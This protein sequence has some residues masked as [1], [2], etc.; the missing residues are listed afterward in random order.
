MAHLLVSSFP[1]SSQ[2]VRWEYYARYL[3]LGASTLLCSLPCHGRVT[4]KSQVN[5]LYFLWLLLCLGQWRALK[6]DWV[7]GQPWNQGIHRLH[8]FPPKLSLVAWY[9]YMWKSF[10]HVQLFVTPWTIAY[11]APLSMEFRQAYWEWVA[12]PFS[13]GSSQPRD[14]TQVSCIAGE[15]FTIWATR[16]AA[17]CSELSVTTS[18]KAVRLTWLLLGSE[19]FLIPSDLECV[20]VNLTL[21]S[22]VTVPNTWFPEA[23]TSMRSPFVIKPP[24]SILSVAS[25]SF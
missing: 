12:V 9:V 16:G 1:T 14:W 18:L 23:Y 21:N 7:E 11:Q 5:G 13:R 22:L 17:W 15:F 20:I 24:W 4:N 19:K 2:R 10:S 8:S 6:G 3:P 25:N